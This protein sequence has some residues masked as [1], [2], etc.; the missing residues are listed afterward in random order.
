MIIVPNRVA[1]KN[2]LRFSLGLIKESFIKE[3]F[4]EGASS[5][6]IETKCLIYV[7]VSDL[8]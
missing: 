3:S 6:P 1:T 4:A 7:N 5:G 2:I 8:E